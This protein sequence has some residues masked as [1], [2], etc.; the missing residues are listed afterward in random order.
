M[1][2]YRH[3][4]TWIIAEQI[5]SNLYRENR[6][7]REIPKM[8]IENSDDWEDIDNE[9]EIC[10]HKFVNN[11]CI[12]CQ[13]RYGKSD[14]TLEKYLSDKNITHILGS[15]ATTHKIFSIY[16]KIKKVYTLN[17]VDHPYCWINDWALLLVT[18][19]FNKLK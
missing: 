10:N 11:I 3:K 7:Q 4:Q 19:K 16:W 9:T 15:P 17:K 13:E 8:I 6:R 14:Y 18:K 12:D 2:K 1:K 5:T